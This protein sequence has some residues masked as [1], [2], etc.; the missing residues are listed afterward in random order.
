MGF[1]KTPAELAAY[2]ETPARLFPGAQM[3]G[4]LFQTRPEIVARLLPPPLE[5]AEEPGALVFIAE[6]PK[7]NLGPGYREAALF[8]KCRY[9]GE[10]GTYCLSMPIDSEEVRCSNGRDVFGFPKKLAKIH[11]ERSG[12]QVHGWVE[13]RGIRFFEL[14]V[15]LMAELPALAPTGPSFLFKALPR[16]DLQPGFDGPV[17]LCKQTTEIA[18]SSLEVG[19]PELRF[20]D[21]PHDPWSEVEVTDVI[22]GFY[23]ISDNTMRPGEVIAKVDGD[24]YLPYHFKNIDFP[25]GK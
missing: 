22:A 21:S 15:E 7:T 4:A 3:L 24:A 2:F 25:I 13:R 17:L 23:L 8:L 9:Q 18:L 5:P 20:H 1:V 10:A 14:K 19:V 16:I 12:S 11:L 6:Y